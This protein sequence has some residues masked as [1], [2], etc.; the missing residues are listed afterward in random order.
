MRWT[1][2][3]YSSSILKFFWFICSIGHTIP[4]AKDQTHHFIIWN[5]VMS[6]HY[7]ISEFCQ[8]Y[9]RVGHSHTNNFIQIFRKDLENVRSFKF[10]LRNDAQFNRTIYVNLFRIEKK[11]VL[12]LI[13][14]AT[15][16]RA[17]FWVLSV[18]A[19][20][21]GKLFASAGLMFTL[22]LWT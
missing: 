22:V 9:W 20:W 5:P 15:S 10:T 12:H 14:G 4:V 17:A 2:A 11:T 3:V 8:Q 19:L 1:A 18:S 16:N 7:Y 21:F 6:C 13:D